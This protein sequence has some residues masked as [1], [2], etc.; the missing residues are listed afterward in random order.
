VNAVAG[1]TSLQQETTDIA[2]GDYT[3][4]SARGIENEGNLD[5]T[6][7]ESVDGSE[8]WFVILQA[9]IPVRGVQ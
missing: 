1:L 3:D 9:H 8:N 6:A 5:T 7:L 4:Q 2:I